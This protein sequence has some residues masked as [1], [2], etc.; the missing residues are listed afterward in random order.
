MPSTFFYRY[1]RADNLRVD[2]FKCPPPIKS[3]LRE[4]DSSIPPH[5]PSDPA[6]NV[7]EDAQHVLAAL[8][9]KNQQQQQHQHQQ[10]IESNQSEYNLEPVPTEG[11][12][13]DEPSINISDLNPNNLLNCSSADFEATINHLFQ[14]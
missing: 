1:C 13:D 2:Q 3:L 8:E 6:T 5:Q 7:Y 4:S 9:E 12:T 11:E 10:Q 14:L